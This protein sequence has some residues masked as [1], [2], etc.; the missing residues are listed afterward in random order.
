M[1]TDIANLPLTGGALLAGIAYGALSLLVTGPLV[2][3]RTI[4]KSGWPA[5]C[6]RQIPSAASAPQATAVP[7]LDCADVLGTIYGREGVAFCA[8]HGD[9]VALPFKILGTV[10]GQSAEAARRRAQDRASRAGSA[11]GCATGL[12]LEQRRYDFALYAGSARL[13]TPSP[14]RSLTAELDRAL[15]SSTCRVMP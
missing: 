8:R 5:L 15:S 7:S 9:T 13:V 4:A 14:V 12:V 1:F 11:C 3:E 6:A 2:A 10:S